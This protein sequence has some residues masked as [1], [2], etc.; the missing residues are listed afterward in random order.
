MSWNKNLIHQLSS[1]YDII[2]GYVYKIN[3][4]LFINSNYCCFHLLIPNFLFMSFVVHL[5]LWSYHHWIL[6]LHLLAHRSL[7]SIPYVHKI[8]SS[9]SEL[10]LLPDFEDFL[11]DQLNS[12]LPSSLHWLHRRRLSW[13]AQKGQNYS[14]QSELVTQMMKIQLWGRWQLE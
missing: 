14:I 6:V 7:I 11:I 10:T 9:I 3:I 2:L 1:S 4:Y 8:C 5:F 13:R 12:F